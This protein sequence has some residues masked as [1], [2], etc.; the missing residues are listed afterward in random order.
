MIE[1]HYIVLAFCMV[2]VCILY[3]V[4]YEQLAE[5]SEKEWDGIVERFMN[6]STKKGFN[7]DPAL[8]KSNLDNVGPITA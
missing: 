3:H 4:G 5:L 2:D 7:F 1:T 8:C 6:S